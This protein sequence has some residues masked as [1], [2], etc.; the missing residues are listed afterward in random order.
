MKVLIVFAHPEKQSLNHSLLEVTTNYL[1]EKNHEVKVVDLYAEH[2]KAGIDQ[3]DFLNHD[4]GTRLYAMRDSG[5]AFSAGMLSEDIKEAQAKLEWADLIIFQFP[6]W[7]YSM[8]ALMK[9]WIDRV[10]TQN[11]A[12]AGGKEFKNAPLAGR[13]AFI[14]ST[15]G[16]TEDYYTKGKL[17]EIDEV[18]FPIQHGT[19]SY[20]GFK[21]LPAIIG[22]NADSRK[23]NCFEITS[24][25]IKERI[26]NIDNVKPIYD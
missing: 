1:K 2:W 17:G 18:F 24:K 26:D 21:V 16:V 23:S 25:I 20:A 7:W 5:S 15:V 13:K 19:F 22:Y 11:F 4:R 14:I 10:L 12:Y 3:D 8:P 9:G 6:M